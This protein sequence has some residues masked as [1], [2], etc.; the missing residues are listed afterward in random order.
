VCPCLIQTCYATPVPCHD[1]AFLKANSQGHGTARHGRVMAIA[2]HVSINIGFPMT[3]C[4]LPACVRLLPAI[5]RNSTKVFRSI[6]I[7]RTVG[8]AVRIFPAT[9]R[10]FT[11]VTALSENGRGAAWRGWINAARHDR[12]TAWARHG[13][14][15]LDL[16]DSKPKTW[17]GTDFSMALYFPKYCRLSLFAEPDL[18]HS[19]WPS[20]SRLTPVRCPTHLHIYDS[21]PDHITWWRI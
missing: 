6:P 19:N 3:P 17:E 18:R 21:L 2:W 5:T 10:T 8:L 14:C 16:M 13:M 20:V 12:G 15:E 11:K 9:T 4:G 7:P 1:Y